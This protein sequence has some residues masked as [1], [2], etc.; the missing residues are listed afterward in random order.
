MYPTP[1]EDEMKFI[2]F[3]LCDFYMIYAY[4]IEKISTF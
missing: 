3:S 4:Y 2:F 1:Y